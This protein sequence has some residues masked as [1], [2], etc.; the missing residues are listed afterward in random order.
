MTRKSCASEAMLRIEE[1][2]LFAPKDQIAN[3]CKFNPAF[4]PAYCLQLAIS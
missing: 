3:G 2:H 1:S 4:V